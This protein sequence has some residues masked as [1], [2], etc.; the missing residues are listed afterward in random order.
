MVLLLKL[1][2]KACGKVYRALRIYRP[3]TYIIFF[4]GDVIGI[5]RKAETI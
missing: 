4:I 1:E 3:I 5:E 2:S